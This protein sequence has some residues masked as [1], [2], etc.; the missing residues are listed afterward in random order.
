[1]VRVRNRVGEGGRGEF[2]RGR[3]V[4]IRQGEGGVS[5]GGCR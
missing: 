1:M 2:G 5:K 4:R 3:R